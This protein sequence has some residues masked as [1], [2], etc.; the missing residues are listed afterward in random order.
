MFSHDN[1]LILLFN[2]LIFYPF[3]KIFLYYL[4]KSRLVSVYILGGIVGALFFVA[5]YNIFPRFGL[6]TAN[7]TA[8]GASAS[9]IAVCMAISILAK[10]INESK[11][12][13]K[14]NSLIDEAV[15]DLAGIESLCKLYHELFAGEF[16]ETK[17]STE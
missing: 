10:D 5:S 16:E 6:L 3:S 7:A 15:N 17:P 4:P 14:I 11:T 9:V 2:L 8:I 13:A 12:R 1:F